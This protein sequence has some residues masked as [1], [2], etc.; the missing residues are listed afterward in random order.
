MI[1][2]LLDREKIRETFGKY[3][4]PEIRDHILAGKIPFNGDT[5]NLAARIQEMTKIFKCDILI[6]KTT[7]KR[8][9]HSFLLE[10]EKG[11]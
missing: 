5:V 9:E 3:V 6:S 2:G 1:K 7:V 10:E 4:T 8:L 11:H